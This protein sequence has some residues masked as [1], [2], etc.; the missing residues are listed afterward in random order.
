MKTLVIGANGNLGRE[1]VRQLAQKQAVVAGVRNESKFIEETNVENVIFDYDKPETFD[2]ALE[3]VTSVFLQAP[4]L[5][6]DSFK[7][8]SPFINTLKDKGIKRVVFNSAL[9]VDHNEEAPLRKIERK[10]MSDDFYY[11]FTRPNFFIENFTSGFAAA[12]L[13]QGHVIVANAGEGKLSFIS[14]KD[15]AAV[16]VESFMNDSH[17]KKAYNLTGKEALSHFEIAKLFTQATGTEINYISLSDEDMK[18]GAMDS[19]VPESSADYLVMLY[20]LA[21]AGLLEATTNDVVEVTGN[22]P[23]TFADVI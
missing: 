12:P 14:I 10:L 8:L 1:I 23:K 7:R 5:D 2:K 20:S 19:G 18:Q 16:V 13:Q 4:S 17:I 3:N 22:E 11:T 15:I 9:G 6:A 21:K